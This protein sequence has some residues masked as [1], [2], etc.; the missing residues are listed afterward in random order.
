MAN[1]LLNIVFFILLGI[2][3]LASCTKNEHKNQLRIIAVFG[4]QPIDC[5]PSLVVNNVQWQID[6]LQFFV[7]QVDYQTTTGIWHPWP[8]KTM[9]YQSN[10]VALLGENCQNNSSSQVNWLIDFKPVVKLS[11]VTA[12]RFNLG[13]PFTLN[14][15]NPLIQNSPLN[16]SSMFWVWQTGH[17]FLRLEMSS[18]TDDW[19]FHLG[20]TGCKAASAMRAPELPCLQPNLQRF[21]VNTDFSQGEHAIIFD[22]SKLIHNVTLSRQNGCQSE[23][24]NVAC[25]QLLTNIG[26]TNIDLA[27]DQSSRGIFYDD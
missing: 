6:Q 10:N 27:D 19:L 2:F 23:P 7:S 3:S 17:K 13:V 18:E 26:L 22:L 4:Q 12:I 8:M 24:E 15:L 1:Y 20:S 11:E 9:P 16:D 25:Q 21:H 5:S 14:H